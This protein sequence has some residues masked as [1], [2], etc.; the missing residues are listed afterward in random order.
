MRFHTFDE[1]YLRRLATG[2]PIV[3]D[4]FSAYFSNLLHLK[5]RGRVRTSDVVEDIGQETLLRVL[6]AV[7]KE[8]AIQ[9]PERLGAFVNAVCNNVLREHMR[10]ESRGASI[11][12]Q[13]QE[14]IDE[15]AD[16]DRTLVN[17]QRKRQV[18][19]VLSEM[20]TKDRELLNAFF[21]QEVDKTELCR[22]LNV[23][24]DYLR[25][26]LHRAKER[27][28]C[29][30]QKRDGTSGSTR[31]AAPHGGNTLDDDEE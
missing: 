22:R 31:K 29:Q 5:L 11:G 7:R 15:T 14:P 9:H 18:E 2:D 20:K 17:S 8:G 19:I 12:D 28:R 23:N 3:E 27:F 16:L 21:L 26:L 4:H 10:R 30:F 6:L 24:E 25:V 1:E 13:N